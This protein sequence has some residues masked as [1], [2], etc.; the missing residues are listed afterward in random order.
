MTVK[1]VADVKEIRI[2][3]ERR[4]AY[5]AAMVRFLMEE[6]ELHRSQGREAQIFLKLREYVQVVQMVAFESE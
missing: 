4:P 5:N 6:T 1:Q 3:P 2:H